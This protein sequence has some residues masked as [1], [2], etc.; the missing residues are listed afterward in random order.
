MVDG[1]LL[2][3]KGYVMGWTYDIKTNLA[4]LAAD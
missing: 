2:Q 3:L 1:K 4:A